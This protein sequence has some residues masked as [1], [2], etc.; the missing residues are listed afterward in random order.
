METPPSI[1]WETYVIL[2]SIVGV[3]LVGLCIYERFKYHGCVQH[4]NPDAQ[5]LI[6]IL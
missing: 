5:D 1:L 3:T 2:V 6:V 4:E